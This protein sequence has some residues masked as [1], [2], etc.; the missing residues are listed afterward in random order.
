MRKELCKQYP[1][2]TDEINNFTKE[3]VIK[4]INGSEEIKSVMLKKTP[5]HE[6]RYNNVKLQTIS[7]GKNL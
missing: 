2:F 4:F 6:E 7:N 1:S 3:E 5:N